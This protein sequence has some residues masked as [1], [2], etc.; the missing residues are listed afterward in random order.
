MGVIF[1]PRSYTLY[2]TSWHNVLIDSYWI[3]LNN[4]DVTPSKNL[5]PCA[6]SHSI[7]PS[8]HDIFTVRA[9]RRL[10]HTTSLMHTPLLRDSIKVEIKCHT[11]T[12][13][14]RKASDRGRTRNSGTHRGGRTKVQKAQKLLH[15]AFRAPCKY[16]S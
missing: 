7:I 2:I 16:F 11:I 10:T 6:S 8:I 3:L 5:E 4:R 14:N 13:N 12:Q 1:A 9:V 15:P